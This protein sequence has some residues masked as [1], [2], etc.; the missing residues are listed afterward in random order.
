MLCYLAGACSC[1]FK[2]N[3]PIDATYWRNL[4]STRLKDFGNIQCFNPAKNFISNLSY[5]ED[6]F[7]TQNIYYLNKCDIVLINLNRLSDSYGT[8]FELVWA[9]CNNKPVISFG[10]DEK[11]QSHPHIRRIIGTHFQTLEEAIEFITQAYI[12]PVQ[13]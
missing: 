7:V 4:A 2:E 12:H 10:C 8:L 6:A 1:H 13:L 9:Y 3:H 11:I 5:E